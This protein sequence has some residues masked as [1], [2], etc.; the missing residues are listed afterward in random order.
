MVRLSGLIDRLRG[1]ASSA[2]PD[3]RH[4]VERQ[5]HT[6]RN[7]FKKQQGRYIEFLQLTTDYAN[8]YLLDISSTVMGQE[9]FLDTLEKRLD[10]AKE[11]HT[12]ARE[13]L[14]SF[15]SE[16]AGPVEDILRTV[17]PEPLPQDTG[18]MNE[19]D[20]ALREIGAVTPP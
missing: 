10:M 4:E 16:I 3:R 2:P 17:S 9:E 6:L 8:Q 20:S 19:V 13:L 15:E 11:R 7:S 12:H 18:I 5:V 14:K 1:L